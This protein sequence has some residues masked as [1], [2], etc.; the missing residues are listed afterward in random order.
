MKREWSKYA[1]KFGLWSPFIKPFWESGGMDIVTDYIQERAK[2][3]HKIV[4]DSGI[5][6]RAFIETPPEK[7]KVFIFGLCPYHTSVKTETGN[8]TVADGLALSCSR[9]G[10][11]QP[12]LEQYYNA[13]EEEF[14]SGLNLKLFRNPDLKF[15]ADQ[16]VFLGNIA[17]T[18]EYLKVN[19]HGEI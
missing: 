19:R 17:L 7:V 9:T 1:D 16:G 18:T 3:G 15:L 14:Y 6:Y 2:K 12:S 8:V 13:V 10:V 5:T 11:L 4:P